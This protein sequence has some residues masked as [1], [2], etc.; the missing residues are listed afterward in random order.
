MASSLFT[1][2]L[3][4]VAADLEQ[5]IDRID[6]LMS[7]GE[8][9]DR[10]VRVLAYA[11]Y[12]NADTVRVSGRVVRFESDRKASGG[13]LRK[14]RAMIAVYNSKELPG[15]PV[16][17]EAYGQSAETV[18]DDEGYFSFE[19]AIAAPLPPRATWE[20]ATLTTPRHGA[21]AAAIKVP[22]IAPGKDHHWGVISDID[23]TVVETG[24]TDFRRNWRRIL[25]EDP[26]GPDRG[27]GRRRA[28][29]DDRRRPGGTGAPVLLR[30]LVAVEPVRLHRR[31]HGA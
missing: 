12:R 6:D 21:Q 24:A 4:S 31:V 10:R 2:F 11:G 7:Q 3:R 27:P 8:G 9:H 17:C 5:D 30:L 29:Q 23:D 18:S 16:R 25:A 22:V 13:T 14:L 15:V 19:L 1:N 28:L 26:A 20:S